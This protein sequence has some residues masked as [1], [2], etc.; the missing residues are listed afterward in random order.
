M[1]Q[2]CKLQSGVTEKDMR[3]TLLNI[4]DILYVEND[5]S[6]EPVYNPDKEWEAETIELVAEI[7]NN[8]VEG[9]PSKKGE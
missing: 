5:D 3:N 7:I 6:G 4:F 9:I 1:S 2:N 8:V